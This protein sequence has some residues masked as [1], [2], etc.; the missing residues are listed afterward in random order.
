M[1]TD[2]PITVPNKAISK[3]EA[4]LRSAF[5]VV[6]ERVLGP[7]Q[8]VLLRH[9]DIRLGGVPDLSVTGLGKTSWIEFKHG[10]PYFESPG[11]QELMMMRLA[12]NGYYARYLIWREREGEGKTTNIVNPVELF[13]RGRDGQREFVA[14][15][16]TAGFN[17]GWLAMEILKTHVE[18]S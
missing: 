7:L 3:A 4:E 16:A 14:E 17:H 6:A 5:M 2:T 9:E 11:N 18:G 13:R 8:F 15:R 12:K 1:T 10:T